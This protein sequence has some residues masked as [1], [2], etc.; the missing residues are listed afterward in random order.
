MSESRPLRMTM[1][2]LVDDEEDLA[3]RMTMFRTLG[4][5]IVD[6]VVPVPERGHEHAHDRVL[7]R[8]SAVDL[9]AEIRRRP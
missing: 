2:R 6:G 4:A 9:R 8:G 7:A 5:T 3:P 1:L